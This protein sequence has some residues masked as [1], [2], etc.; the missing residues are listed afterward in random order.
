MV[1]HL[2]NISPTFAQMPNGITNVVYN[3]LPHYC[4]YDVIGITAL[5]P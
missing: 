1:G 4:Q 5:S 2:E 3:C